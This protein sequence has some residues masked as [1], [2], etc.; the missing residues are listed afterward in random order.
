MAYIEN[1][2]YVIV[3]DKIECCRELALYIKGREI[4][5]KPKQKND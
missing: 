1:Y 2:D 4:E 3:N 5:I